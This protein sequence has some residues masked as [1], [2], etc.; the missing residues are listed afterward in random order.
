MFCWFFLKFKQHIV[1]KLH[2]SQIK[3]C[4]DTVLCDCYSGTTIHISLFT[5]GAIY[6]IKQDRKK[7]KKIK[8]E[9]QN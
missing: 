6:T 2:V 8:K 5:P 3:N 4:N 7:K 1:N 9:R